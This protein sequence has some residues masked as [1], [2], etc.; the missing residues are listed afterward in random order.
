MVL[1]WLAFTA[2]KAV[3]MK[4][5]AL[6]IAKLAIKAIVNLKRTDVSAIV[7]RLELGRTFFMVNESDI[8]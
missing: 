8:S 6:Y 2:Y 4:L 5:S 3:L 1:V 7:L